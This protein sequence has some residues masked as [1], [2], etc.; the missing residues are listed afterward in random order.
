M[1]YTELIKQ[2]EEPI[3]DVTKSDLG[4]WLDTDTGQKYM[5]SMAP[6]EWATYGIGAGLGGLGA[7]GLYRLLN[8]KRS[9]GKALLWALMGAGLG[10][11]GSHAYLRA[12]TN[13]ETGLSESERLRISNAYHNNQ[14]F[15]RLYDQMVETK[16]LAAANDLVKA[17]HSAGNNW[18]AVV[19]AGVGAGAGGWTGNVIANRQ[20]NALTDRLHAR[21]ILGEAEKMYAKGYGNLVNKVN[22][23]NIFG[24]RLIE[25]TRKPGTPPGTNIMQADINPK[26]TKWMRTKGRL[27]GGII[28]MLAMGL[29]GH[30]ADRL[31]ESLRRPR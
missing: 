30:G 5:T 13:P 25:F 7:Y 10:A 2:A 11:G 28:G 8:R 15:K 20:I 1:K 23:K 3:A 21:G 22:P 9:T 19:G 31:N 17:V 29:L 6:S 27:G 24:E 18:R 26:A 14:D 4:N 12:F 16:D